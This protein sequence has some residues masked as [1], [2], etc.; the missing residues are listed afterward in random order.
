MSHALFL[1]SSA[2]FR[3]TFP[4]RVL[5]VLNPKIWLEKHTPC[6]KL[7]ALCVLCNPLGTLLSAV[8]DKAA[9]LG[10][11]GTYRAIP[12]NE[13]LGENGTYRASPPVRLRAPDGGHHD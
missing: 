1:R 3:L 9:R 7:L 10:I 5:S 13:R 4:A 12:L 2:A 11:N 8:L 6:I